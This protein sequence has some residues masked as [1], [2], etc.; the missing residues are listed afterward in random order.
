GSDLPSLPPAHITDAFA[1]LAT[2]DVVLGPAQDGG[3]YLIGLK[4]ADERLFDNLEWGGPQV[5]NETLRIARALQLTVA[6]ISPWFDIDTRGDLASVQ[7]D[8][9]HTAASHTRSWLAR[10]CEKR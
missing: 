6:A 9:V 4:Q 5:Y 8:P 2:H 7:A 1:R 3:Y 10:W